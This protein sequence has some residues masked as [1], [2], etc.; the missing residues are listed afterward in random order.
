[1]SWK[2]YC[3]EKALEPGMPALHRSAKGRVP[4]ATFLGCLVT[5][6]PVP[7]QEDSNLRAESWHQ[8]WD[9]ETEPDQ[10]HWPTF[11]Q[12]MLDRI[13]MPSYPQFLR[14]CNSFP[15]KTA[16]GICGLSPRHFAFIS[17]QAF[18]ALLLLWLGFLRLGVIPG[19][20]NVLIVRLLP[21]A[22][23]GERPIGLFP[24]ATRLLARWLRRTVG[25]H[26]ALA[27][28]R[29][30]F[31]STKGMSSSICAWRSAAIVEYGKLIGREVWHVLL[32]IVKAFENVGH[33][34]LFEAARRYGF[35]P[36]VLRFLITMYRMPRRV[37]IRT[38]VARQVSASKTIVP[39]DAFSDLLL[40]LTLLF[41]MDSMTA[42][43]PDIFVGVVVDDI[44]LITIQKP[45]G[46]DA[47]VMI[48]EAV[49]FIIEDLSRQGLSIAKGEKRMIMTS[50]PAAALRKRGVPS[51][52]TSLFA[53]ASWRRHARNL[54]C[55]Q[56][57]IGRNVAVQNTRIKK[58]KRTAKRVRRI[59]KAGVRIKHVA[60][61]VS[62]G[63]IAGAKFGVEVV[64]MTDNAIRQL[65]SAAHMAI[66]DS[67]SGRS[68]TC[69]LQM[70]VPDR[71]GGADPAIDVCVAPIAS[72][73]CAL[74]D[75]WVPRFILARSL[76]QAVQETICWNKVQGPARAT[77]ASL[78]RIGWSLL[79]PFVW[80]PPRGQAINIDHVA[81]RDLTRLLKIDALNWTWVQAAQ[82]RS[83]YDGLTAAPLLQPLQRILKK[84]PAVQWSGKHSGMLRCY[85][86][87]AP[88]RS[89]CDLCGDTWSQ[90]HT[91]WNCAAGDVFKREYG[92]DLDLQSLAE[93]S[94]HKH[95]YATALIDTS[96]TRFPSTSVILSGCLQLQTSILSST[97]TLLAMVRVST[98][99][100]RSRSAAAGLHVVEWHYSY[101]ELLSRSR[102]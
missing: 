37:C 8:Q 10:L 13:Q 67:P 86:A 57:L 93:R 12:E 31:Y 48:G 89:T 20:I 33:R 83:L 96:T 58:A 73:L 66:V 40:R 30:Y 65:R 29:S 99:S 17:K 70:A 76:H 84:P 63:L 61:V 50:R 56:G 85:M 82:H 94:P 81:P 69:D 7:P 39:G 51:I 44:Q 2:K 64:G 71:L 24:S 78:Q 53:K 19:S 52:L 21:K 5:G 87:A 68:A 91:A 92:M 28:S 35:D 23:G 22:A 26:W 36:V 25:E 102:T 18:D 98:Q 46:Y 27:N 3:A 90:W 100:T 59:M 97:T 38:V 54:G 62:S 43:Y 77:I 88:G 79:S 42:R 9:V 6:M 47:S 16:T 4:W 41:T 49:N 1:M 101:R 72:F 14:L 75:D 80:Q 74:W 45:G 15:A 55:D 34:F 60:H 32:D 95:V 11:S